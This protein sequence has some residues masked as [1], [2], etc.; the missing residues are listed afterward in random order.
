MSAI[1]SDTASRLLELLT[2]LQ[3]RRFWPGE[4]LAERLGVTTRTLRRDVDRLRELGYTVAATSGP[5]GGYQSSN[6][7]T[8]PPVLLTEDE[9]VA[10][11]AALRGQVGAGGEAVLPVLAKLHQL[12]PERLRARAAAV[13]EQTLTLGGRRPPDLRLLPPLATACRDSEAVRL[14]YRPAHR[15]AAERTVHPLRLVHTGNGRWYLVAW[16]PGRGAWRTLRVD[17]IEALLASGPRVARPEPP[18]DLG[19]W[20]SE[21][22]AAAPYPCVARLLVEGGVEGVRAR[23][24]AWI[25]VVESAGPTSST[26]VLGGPSWDVVAAGALLLGQPFRVVGP[27]EALPAFRESAARLAAAVDA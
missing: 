11:T 21:S 14:R 2:L 9:A 3:S 26:V 16:D 18:A 27:P 13:H 23:I 24:P 5:G 22:I 1:V 12:L 15:E 25:G 10:L 4:E 19:R 6:G 17:R 20:V 7:T 8:L